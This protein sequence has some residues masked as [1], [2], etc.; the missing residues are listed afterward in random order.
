MCLRR[1]SSEGGSR[2]Q[3]GEGAAVAARVAGPVWAPVAVG[4][5][6]VWAGVRAALWFPG[7]VARRLGAG[8][9]TRLSFGSVSAALV[10]PSR[11]S[12]CVDH[13]GRLRVCVCRGG[14]SLGTRGVTVTP[15]QA[16]AAALPLAP[17][18]GRRLGSNGE[19]PGE[20]AGRAGRLRPPTSRGRGCR[21]PFSSLL[22]GAPR[23]PLSPS[24][25]PECQTGG[26][27]EPTTPPS[28][29]PW[30]PL[31]GDAAPPPRS[32]TRRTLGV[33]GAYSPAL[34]SL[35]PSPRLTRPPP[36]PL[37]SGGE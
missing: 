5:A 31:G 37:E 3:V 36:A 4:A 11:P 19:A 28:C 12:R 8:C 35:S 27:D 6:A 15:A 9:G 13:P 25:R 2:R 22:F 1:R 24:S 14:G 21:S 20:G 16:A 18:P 34:S 7:C 23:L 10:F 32:G 33:L 30:K 26:G 17:H 29:F